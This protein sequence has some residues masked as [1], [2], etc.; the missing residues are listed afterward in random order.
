MIFNSIEYAL[1][2]PVVF[3]LYWFVFDRWIAKT[4]KQLLLQNAFV[5]AASYVF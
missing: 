3:F 4:K 1:F 2:L 5:L